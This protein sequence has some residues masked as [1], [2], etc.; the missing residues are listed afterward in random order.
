MTQPVHPREAPT[1]QMMTRN[2]KNIGR[3]CKNHVDRPGVTNGQVKI[4]KQK[5]PI[6]AAQQKLWDLTQKKTSFHHQ[7]MTQPWPLLSPN[8]LKVTNNQPFQKVT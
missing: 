3:P 4:G 8:Q 5:L 6:N 7:V 1:S 2:S